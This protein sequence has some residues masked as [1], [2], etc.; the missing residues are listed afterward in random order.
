MLKSVLALLLLSFT[1]AAHAAGNGSIAYSI[2][3]RAGNQNIAVANSAGTNPVQWTWGPDNAM[4]SWSADGMSIA[5]VHRDSRTTQQSVCLMGAGGSPVVCPTEGS[6]PMFSPMVV[7]PPKIAYSSSRTGT[8]E[9]WLMS[10]DG[11]NQ[12]QLTNSPGLSKAHAVWSPDGLSL[13]YAQF[14]ADNSHNAIWI[15]GADGS[16]PHQLTFPG[17]VNVDAS[18]RTINT[19]DDANSPTWGANN[20]IA[21]WSGKEF[22]NGQVWAINPDGT[23]RIQLTAAAGNNDDPEWSPDGTQLLFSTNRNGPVEM[24]A[25]NG[26]GSRP[27]RLAASRAGPLPGDASWQPLQAGPAP[28]PPSPH[29]LLMVGGGNLLL[30]GGGKLQCV[31]SC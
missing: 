28:P 3:D 21:F 27:R 31:G 24:W 25:M 4:P 1:A 9:I 6:S 30:V 18:G 22:T 20:R 5:F 23:G 8:S 19:A 7:Q 12:F 13:A 16:N 10:P 17:P 14:N 26:D 29:Y 11:S 15:V 2:T